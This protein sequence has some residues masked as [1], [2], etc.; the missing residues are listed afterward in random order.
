MQNRYIIEGVDPREVVIERIRGLSPDN[1]V[2]LAFSCGKDAIAAWL[3][4]RDA[5]MEVYPYYRY[6]IPGLEFVEES[7]SYYEKFFGVH[8]QRMPHPQLHAWLNAMLFQVPGNCAVIEAADLETFDF[9][10]LNSWAKEEAG[11]PE[12]CWT[13]SGV[14]AAD[15]INRRTAVKNHGPINFKNRTFLPVWD[16]KKDELIS[17]LRLAGILL[18]VDYAI[19][20]RSFDGLDYRFIYGIKKYFPRDYQRIVELFPLIDLELFRYEHC[21][22]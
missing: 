7:L 6:L 17:L 20:G 16:M 12:D 8:I 15:S 18:P 14:R 5:G 19:F 22:R 3:I 9:E 13:A 4:L 2:Q 21:G 10:M 11:I 1:R